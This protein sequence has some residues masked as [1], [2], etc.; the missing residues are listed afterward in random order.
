MVRYI[1]LSCIVRCYI[2]VSAWQLYMHS[3]TD[4][5]PASAARID[6]QSVVVIGSAAKFPL[7]KAHGNHC[8]TK[9]S[10]MGFY[11]L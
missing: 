9:S 5:P 10:F 8:T 7:V 11:L 3:T 4:L 2:I 1:V 6:Y